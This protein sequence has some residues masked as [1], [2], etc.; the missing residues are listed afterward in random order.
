MRDNTAT[1]SQEMDRPRDE[2]NKDAASAKDDLRCDWRSLHDSCDAHDAHDPMAPPEEVCECTCLHCGR[3]FM[4]D[5]IWFQKVVNA[6]DGFKGFWMCPTPNCSGAGFC[7]DIFP[8][9]P[10]HPANEGWVEFDEEDFAEEFDPSDAAEEEA[11]WDPTEAKYKEM[12]EDAFIEDDIEGEEWKYA[13]EQLPEIAD[14]EKMDMDDESRM[15]DQPDQR[16]REV[17]WSNREDRPI[18]GNEF[19]GNEDDIPF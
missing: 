17:D 13:G 1:M 10:N 14:P 8:T 4:S 12:D 18:M 2:K 7:F 11:E 3:V 5:Q 15:Y 16:P 19:T 9:D 6:R